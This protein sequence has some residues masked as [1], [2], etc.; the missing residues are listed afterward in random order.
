MEVCIDIQ[1]SVTQRAGV[2]RYTKTL[3]EHL[4]PAA[5]EDLLSLF[6]FDFLRRG[7]PVDA[8]N[9][10][11]R[12]V[13][14]CP[15]RIAQKA[16]S[17]AGWP[18]FD[19]YA[20]RADLYHFPNFVLPPLRH[21]RSVV[22]IHDVAFLRMPETVEE[23]NLRYLKGRIVDTANRC[24]AIVTVSE[25]SAAEIATLLNVDPGK[26]H[27]VYEGVAPAFRKQ[28]QAV[29]EAAKLRFGITGSY[30]LF[31]G[32][33]EPRKNIPFLIE[34]FEKMTDYRGRIVIAGSPGWKCEPIFERMRTSS[35]AKDILCINY[36]TDE[37]LPALYAGADLFMFPSLYE[38]FGLPPLEAMACGTPVLAS[39]AGS[40]P[41]VL[42]NAACIP[43][44]FD[45]GKWAE[46]AMSA[47]GS[48]DLSRKGIEHAAK[49]TWQETAARTWEIYRKVA[50]SHSAGATT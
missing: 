22:T 44:G 19:F 1:A 5:G 20:G 24:D 31:V 26:I 10:R 37:H 23:R 29:V 15:G 16:W 48:A 17:F 12:S 36:V 38:G 6:Y 27:A 28:D 14:W 34:T 50:G 43:D 3:V 7:S 46:A 30:V 8:T 25:F 33:V 47:I 13:R 35:R 21:G 41:E 39:N 42:G 4:A 40:L 18:P 11:I 9:A 32:T 45:S 49:F 2:G